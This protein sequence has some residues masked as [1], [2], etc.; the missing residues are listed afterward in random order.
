MSA[1]TTMTIRVSPEVKDKLD[2]LAV[3]TQRSK[4]FLAGQALA[5]YVDHELEYIEGIKEARADIAAGRYVTH[6]Q[7][8]AE[9]RQIVED[10]RRKKAARG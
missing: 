3:E 10:E 5:A 2:R 9:M 4:S 1:S 8:I 7:A 6:E